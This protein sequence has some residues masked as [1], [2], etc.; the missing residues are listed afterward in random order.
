MV[1]TVDGCMWAGREYPVASWYIQVI[2]LNESLDYY[3]WLLLFYEY[4][5]AE[6]A[7]T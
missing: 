1:H 5:T 2:L 6:P 3:F 4:D 7:M